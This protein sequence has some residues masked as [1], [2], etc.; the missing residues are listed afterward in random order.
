MVEHVFFTIFIVNWIRYDIEERF[1]SLE[2]YLLHL[3]D[4]TTLLFC[5]KLMTNIFRIVNK[6]APHCEDMKIAVI[7]LIFNFIVTT[8]GLNFVPKI[9]LKVNLEYI[10]YFLVSTIFPANCWS[11]NRF[12][13]R[14]RSIYTRRNFKFWY[15]S[16]SFSQAVWLWGT[17]KS[18]ASKLFIQPTRLYGA[19]WKIWGRTG[20]FYSNALWIFWH[21]RRWS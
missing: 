14:S 9:G 15:F 2:I 7:S 12:S 13:R 19:Q 6:R 11:S 8:K 10:I 1:Q 20:N 21:D 5:T 3:F 4:F 16:E 18:S 17:R